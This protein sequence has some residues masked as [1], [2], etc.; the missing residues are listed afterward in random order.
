MANIFASLGSYRVP[1]ASGRC[2]SGFR[3]WS[4]PRRSPL[5]VGRSARGRCGW[6]SLSSSQSP[7][8]GASRRLCTRLSRGS[9]WQL[10]WR[11]GRT[12][13]GAA[14]VRARA[15]CSGRRLSGGRVRADYRYPHRG[16]CVAGLGRLLRLYPSV[17]RWSDL[18]HASP[19]LLVAR[20]ADG[21][22]DLPVRGRGHVGGTRR[23]RP[24]LWTPYS[25][26]LPGSPASPRPPSRTSWAVRIR[27]TS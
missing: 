8:C 15:G 3:T 11:F 24:S 25:P 4:W 10:C 26:D 22:R 21:G 19:R 2:A 20:P 13:G 17:L 7:R 14:G 1:P 6:D 18:R 9:R 5:R 27:T 12:A 16:R 23:A